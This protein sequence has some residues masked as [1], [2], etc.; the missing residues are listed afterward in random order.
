MNPANF[1]IR[2]GFL[3]AETGAPGPVFVAPHAAIA[4]HKPGDNQDLNT[5]YIA[6]KLATQMGGRALVS[7]VSRER[8]VGIDYF[9]N[10]PDQKTAMD[11]YALFSKGI[12][13]LT[14]D[15]RKQYAWVARD[16]RQHE[17]KQK[18]FSGF[19]EEIR[20][21]RSPVVFVHR[22]YLNPIRHP[23]AIDVIPFNYHEEVQRVVKELNEKYKT[24]F[25]RLFPLYLEAFHF[26]TRCIMMKLK[27]DEEKKIK[28]FRS[29]RPDLKRR[30]ARFRGKIR[31]EP[32]LEITYMRNFKGEK[33][34][35][36]VNKYLSDTKEPILHIEINEFL[37]RR[38][39]NIAVY[40]IEDLVKEMTKYADKKL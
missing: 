22:Q 27:L 34:K 9:R 36:L 3:I 16:E 29:R 26:K 14:R 21:S 15:Y 1:H 13:R 37:T 8:N 32:Y 2:K 24:V 4:F 25:Q 33:V 6:Y 19:W 30:T 23:S 10:P 17:S 38:F 11:N 35:N 18:M 40:I 39:P 28:F 20:N 7:L 5:H 31:A 12:S